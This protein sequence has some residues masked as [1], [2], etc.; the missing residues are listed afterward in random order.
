LVRMVKGWT[1]RKR[2]ARKEKILASLSSGGATYRTA[3]ELETATG[4][5]AAALPLLAELSRLGLVEHTWLD[6][7]G[8]PT[9]AYRLTESGRQRVE[10]EIARVQ[11]DPRSR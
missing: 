9:L 1:R 2:E 11:A 3:E 5:R 4:L 8:R 6:V 10:S 7:D